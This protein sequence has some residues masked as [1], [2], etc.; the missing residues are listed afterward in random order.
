[1]SLVGFQPSFVNSSMHSALLIAALMVIAA[2]LFIKLEST[3]SHCV[4]AMSCKLT[5]SLNARRMAD[6]GGEGW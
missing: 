5:P 3:K 2:L 6:G 4:A 1:M